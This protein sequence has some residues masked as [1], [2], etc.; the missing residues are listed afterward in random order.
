V[1]RVHTF[2]PVFALPGWTQ[3]YSA[4]FRTGLRK[5][6]DLNCGIVSAI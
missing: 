2:L 5:V 4:P 1:V 6:K 3:F